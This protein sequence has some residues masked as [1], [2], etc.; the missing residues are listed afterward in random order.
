MT[1]GMGGQDVH[2][3]RYVARRPLEL[4]PETQLAPVTPP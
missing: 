1:G 3:V 4:H 2:R